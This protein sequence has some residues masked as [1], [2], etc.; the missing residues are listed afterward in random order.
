MARVFESKVALITGGSSG[1]GRASALAFAREGARVMIADRRAAEGEETVLMIKDTGGEARFVQTDVS[2]ASEVE[3]L[4]SACVEILGGLDYAFNNAGIEGT[5]F[6]RTADYDEDMWDQVIDINLK[7]VW[8]CMKFEIP[9]ML[10]RGKGAIVNMSSVAGLRG[11]SIGVAYHASKHG[12]IGLTKASATEY[13][14]QGIRI[15][16]VC[17]GVIKTDMANRAFFH[18]EELGK[19]VAAMHPMGRVGHPDEVAASVLW[20]CSEAAS[21]VTGHAMPIDGGFLI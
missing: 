9:Q 13:A 11:G 4:V 1:I 5:P 19:R 8:L 17:P 3:A 10:K 16:A 12:V 2:K 20:L 14:A 15:N 21:F 6:V 18:D 7:G